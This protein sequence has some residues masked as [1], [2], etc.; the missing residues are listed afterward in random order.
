MQRKKGK[1]GRKGKKKKDVLIKLEKTD[2]FCAL[3]GVVKCNSL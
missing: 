3:K 1:E 2:P